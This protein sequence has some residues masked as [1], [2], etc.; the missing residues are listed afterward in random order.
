IIVIPVRVGREGNM[1]RLPLP[2]ELP[3]DLRALVLHQKHDVAHERFRRDIAD[4]IRAITSLR[5]SRVVAAE[6]TAITSLRKPSVLAAGVIIVS[7]VVVLMLKTGQYPVQS[8]EHRWIS[9]IELRKSLIDLP[10]SEVARVKLAA[11]RGVAGAQF[12]LGKLYT[13]G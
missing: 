4:L 8:P 9:L 3:E 7:V 11:D 12:D 2:E 6:R 5:Q 13:T 10:P 1:P